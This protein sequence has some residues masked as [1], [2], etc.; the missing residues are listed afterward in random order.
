MGRL[1][2][3]LRRDPVPFATFDR[4]DY[5]HKNDELYTP[6][7]MVT[8]LAKQEEVHQRMESKVLNDRIRV[9]GR[10]LYRDIVLSRT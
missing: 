6:L 1:C 8:R 9:L 10:G 5:R 4:E 7:V 2:E 3:G